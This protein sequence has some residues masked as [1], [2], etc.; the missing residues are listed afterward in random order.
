M[1]GGR[2]EGGWGQSL[3]ENFFANFH[4]VTADMGGGVW[5]EGSGRRGGWE[6]ERERGG[7]GSE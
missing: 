5:T 2:G 4:T 7:G 1:D 6:R 3:M